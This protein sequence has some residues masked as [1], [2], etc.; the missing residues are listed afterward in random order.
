MLNAFEFELNDP[1]DTSP[2]KVPVA[3]TTLVT[4]AVPRVSE[5]VKLSIVA[6]P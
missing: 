5:T 3:P 1:A 6:L 2:L 4:L